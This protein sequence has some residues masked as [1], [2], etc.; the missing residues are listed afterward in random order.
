MCIFGCLLNAID[1][2]ES[3]KTHL[4]QTFLARN[5]MDTP[6]ILTHAPYDTRR[7]VRATRRRSHK[8]NTACHCMCSGRKNRHHGSASYKGTSV[9]TAPL[10]QFIERH[11]VIE[12]DRY[13][14]EIGKQSHRSFHRDHGISMPSKMV[15]RSA[16]NDVD[17]DTAIIIIAYRSC[18]TR[19]NV[20]RT[21]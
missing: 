19:N 8:H 11:C 17:N 12:A 14:L 3:R 18:P 9:T 2:D 1:S 10:R 5:F 13:G 21:P 7:R 20:L 16:N 4:E 6:T 15:S